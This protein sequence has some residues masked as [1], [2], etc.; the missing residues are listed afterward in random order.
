VV[1]RVRVSVFVLYFLNDSEHR[2][3]AEGMPP[4]SHNDSGNSPD[5]L[6]PREDIDPIISDGDLQCLRMDGVTSHHEHTLHSDRDK[7]LVDA[8]EHPRQAAYFRNKPAQIILH[9]GT[10]SKIGEQMPP[11]L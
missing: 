2:F 9:Q 8:D 11:R 7:I 10:P 3:I 4:T 5:I 6:H 1:I